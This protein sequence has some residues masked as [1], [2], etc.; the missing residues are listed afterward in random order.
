MPAKIDVDQMVKLDREHLWHHIMQHKVFETQEPTIMVEGKGCMVKDIHGR[1]F[2]DGVSGG[3]WCINVGYGQE[4]I[5]KAVYEQM[6]QLPYYAGSAGNIP[7]I[8]MAEKLTTMLP[9]LQRVYI[10][11]SGS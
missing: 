8:L 4:S 1:E 11:N 2:L 7:A 6:K 9:Y 5:A 3:V 10:S